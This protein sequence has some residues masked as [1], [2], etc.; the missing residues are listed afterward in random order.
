[1]KKPV[2]I[3]LVAVLLF[4]SAAGLAETGDMIRIWNEELIREF[5]GRT[6]QEVLG[7]PADEEGLNNWT[8]A[9]MNNTIT[10]TVLVSQFCQSA[11]FNARAVNNEMF[12]GIVYR[13]CLNRDVD[14]GGLSNWALAM[15]NGMTVESVINNISVSE[16]CQVYMDS[17]TKN[18]ITEQELGRRKYA[19]RMKSYVKPTYFMEHE[20]ET[21]MMGSIMYGEV[22]AIGG[23]GINTT[24]D[25]L[26]SRSVYVGLDQ[27]DRGFLAYPILV[28]ENHYVCFWE[29]NRIMT[30]GSVPDEDIPVI[31]GM[32][33]DYREYDSSNLYSA[34]LSFRAVFN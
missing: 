29:G 9:I 15:L 4:C 7:R 32:L 25:L 20:D 24:L 5:V 16:E 26:G 21:V 8:T 19:A 6:Y 14:P 30:W 3:L 18:V 11:E 17:L 1:M 2:A 28:G 13:V 10:P 31:L 33:K 34:V 12:I 27:K 23:G 22:E